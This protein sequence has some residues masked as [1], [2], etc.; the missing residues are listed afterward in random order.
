MAKVVALIPCAGQGKRMGA[1]VGK[2]YIEVYGRPLLA[3]TLDVFQRHPLIEEI[4]LVVEAGAESF[5][6]E[7]VVDKYGYTKVKSIV[8][9]GKERQDSVMCGLARL[10]KAAEWVV[11][12]DGARPLI[13]GEIITKALHAAFESG[14]AIVG[15]RAKDTIKIVGRDLTIIETPDRQ[16]LWQVQTPQIFK[17][18]LLERAYRLAV[19]EGWLGTDDASFVERLGEK[20][21]MIEGEYLN[22]KIT[23]PEDLVYFK[24]MLKGAD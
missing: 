14:A 8:A 2:P 1:G 6:R 24:A 10:D 9:G 18:E 4:I 7:T 3:Y 13:S 23:T 15:V 12:H 5:C 22:I 20:I 19:D 17:R 21:K 16:K 11:V